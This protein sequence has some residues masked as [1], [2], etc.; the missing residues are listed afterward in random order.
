[1]SSAASGGS[2]AR[3]RLNPEPFGSKLWR[4]QCI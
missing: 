2:K 1:M 4:V 3:R